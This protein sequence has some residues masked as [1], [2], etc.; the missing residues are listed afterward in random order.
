MEKADLRLCSVR[1]AAACQV[2]VVVE[3]VND[4]APTIVVNALTSAGEAEIDE[5]LPS[6]SF[7]AHLQVTDRDTGPSALVQAV[8]P[9][10][11]R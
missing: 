4:N 6:G 3:D 11:I 5:H 8:T 2:T 9:C 7:V 1:R 10:Q